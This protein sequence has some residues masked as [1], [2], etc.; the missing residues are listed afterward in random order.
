[1]MKPQTQ[2]LIVNYGHTPY[3]VGIAPAQQVGKVSRPGSLP[4]ARVDSS[5]AVPV[6]GL[7][8]LDGTIPGVTGPKPASFGVGVLVA[9]GL[10]VWAA[11]GFKGV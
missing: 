3:P 5:L 4:M 11:S 1:M 6:N 9:V 2:D 8:G 7:Y 10:V